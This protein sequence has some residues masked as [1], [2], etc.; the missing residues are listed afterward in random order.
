VIILAKCP[1]CETE[2]K[3]PEKIWELKG[4]K[5]KKKII[6]GLYLCPKCNRKFRAA[7]KETLGEEIKEKI[8]GKP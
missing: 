1:K 4:G 8:T 7:H 5:S 2:V 3:K 6:V